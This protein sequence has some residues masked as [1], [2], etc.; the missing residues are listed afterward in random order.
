MVEVVKMPKSLSM[1]NP[2]NI[3]GEFTCIHCGKTFK[4]L[5]AM[6]IHLATCKKRALRRDFKFGTIL[7]YVY[8]N[9]R[10]DVYDPL[11]RIAEKHRDNPKWFIGALEYLKEAGWVTQYYAWKEGDYIIKD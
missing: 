3:E 8:M 5:N 6:R 2:S 10:K 7:F 4:K 9:P 1:I 11:E